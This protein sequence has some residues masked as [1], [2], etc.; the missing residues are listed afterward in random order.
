MDGKGIYSDM[1]CNFQYFTRAHTHHLKLNGL[2]TPPLCTFDYLGAPDNVVLTGIGK[3]RF[4]LTS[5]SYLRSHTCLEHKNLI[6]LAI[7]CVGL[8]TFRP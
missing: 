6:C 4:S 5:Y 3:F 2:D 1:F 8:P 7:N